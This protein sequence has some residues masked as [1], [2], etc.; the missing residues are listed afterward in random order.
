MG[1]PGPQ[2][3][4]ADGR[5]LYGPHMNNVRLE[6][7]LDLAGDAALLQPRRHKAPSLVPAK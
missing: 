4:Q 2:D 6:L 7:E 1:M 3:A 5:Y